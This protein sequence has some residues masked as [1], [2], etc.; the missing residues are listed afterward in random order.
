MLF[1]FDK[2]NSNFWPILGNNLG[3]TLCVVKQVEKKY[4]FKTNICVNK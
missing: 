3:Y 2:T 4:S 1:V